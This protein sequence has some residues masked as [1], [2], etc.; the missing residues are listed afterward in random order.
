M[1]ILDFLANTLLGTILVYGIGIAVPATFR[2]LYGAAMSKL[3]AIGLLA[4]WWLIMFISIY[5][6]KGGISPK[7]LPLAIVM[8]ISY[9]I[10]TGGDAKAKGDND[11]DP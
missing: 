11:K 10:L 6:I 8:F 1:E 5:T 4:I 9:G 3:A 2:Y 7:P